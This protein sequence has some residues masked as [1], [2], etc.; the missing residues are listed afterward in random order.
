M[1]RWISCVLRVPR[2][3]SGISVDMSD[4]ESIA[5]GFEAVAQTVG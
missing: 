1:R 4:A 2:T 3:P 5:A